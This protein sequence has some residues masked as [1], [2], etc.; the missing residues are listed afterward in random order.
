MSDVPKRKVVIA[1]RNAHKIREMG[2][3]LAGV[4]VELLSLLDFP[5]LSQIEEKEN[6]FEENARCK[7]LA[8]AR[9]TGL[10]A[11]SDD[12]GLEVDAL[13]GAP[14]VL[15][16]RFAGAEASD[17]DNNQKLLAALKG[18][19]YNCRR[20]RYRCVVA[21]VDARR[22]LLTAGGSVEGVILPAPRGRGGFGYDPLFYYP[23]FGKT[24]AEISA[25]RKHQVSHRGKALRLLR[26][27]LER[28]LCT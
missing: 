17:E 7:A 5:G 2:E 1:S 11:I 9:A 14:G 23:P 28:L 15:S 22:V 6:S 13:G 19:A 10:W 21:L 18:V 24:F 12:S 25:A 20:A 16:S 4:Q 27:R 3:I 26:K 8:A